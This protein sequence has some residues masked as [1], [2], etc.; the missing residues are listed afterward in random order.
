M[1]RFHHLNSAETLDVDTT[2]AEAGVSRVILRP[3]FNDY[4]SDQGEW[5]NGLHVYI[6]TW[7]LKD[8]FFLGCNLTVT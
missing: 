4:S 3:E 8:I 5:R 7:V 2:P 1:S 6:I